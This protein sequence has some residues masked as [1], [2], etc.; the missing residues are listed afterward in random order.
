MRTHQP[1]ACTTTHQMEAV[2]VGNL[3]INSLV[4]MRT[5]YSTPA[6]S[7]LVGHRYRATRRV[8]RKNVFKIVSACKVCGYP[9]REHPAAFQSLQF[10]SSPSY[11]QKHFV[12]PYSKLFWFS[13]SCK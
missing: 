3:Y 5:D 2:V 6:V 1:P 13:L 8:F 7:L 11:K 9:P 12:W 4:Q 10:C